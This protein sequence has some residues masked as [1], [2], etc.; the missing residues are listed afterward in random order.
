MNPTYDMVHMLSPREQEYYKKWFS[1]RCRKASKQRK[2]RN[3]T[4]KENEK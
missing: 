3:V 4:D 1:D 2:K